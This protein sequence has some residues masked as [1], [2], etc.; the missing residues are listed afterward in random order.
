MGIEQG[1]VDSHL[2][3]HGIQNLRVIDASVFPV[4]P[5]CR[6]QNVVYMIGEKVRRHQS[7]S[8]IFANRFLL[9]IGRRF[10]QV[11]LS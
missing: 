1:V 4:I 9:H 11:S 7:C 6:I 8:N 5:D 3:V 2:K 10:D